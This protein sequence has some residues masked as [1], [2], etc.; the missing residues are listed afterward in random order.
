MAAGSH[1]N[2]CAES[3]ARSWSWSPTR[4]S[5]NRLGRLAHLE[6]GKA[7]G[8][9]ARRGQSAKIARV[10]RRVPFGQ[11]DHAYSWIGSE[12]ADAVEEIMDRHSAGTSARSAGKLRA[13]NDIDVAIDDDR[14]AMADMIERSVD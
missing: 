3:R 4:R 10:E 12:P 6:P 1:G 9:P 11:V 2:A 7:L 8:D 14:F 13:V 5:A